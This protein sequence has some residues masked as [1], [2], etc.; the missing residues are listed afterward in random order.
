MAGAAE[1][2]CLNVYPDGSSVCVQLAGWLVNWMLGWLVS[3]IVGWLDD[4]LV[5]YIS[6]WFVSFLS[7]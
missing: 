6:G 5:G 1:T 2:G 3:W 4:W 7:D